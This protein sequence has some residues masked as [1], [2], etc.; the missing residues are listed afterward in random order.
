M[1]IHHIAGPRFKCL[2]HCMRLSYTIPL[3]LLTV[4]DPGFADEWVLYPKLSAGSPILGIGEAIQVEGF[5]G[6]EPAISSD[7][8]EV[9][10]RF[11][12]TLGGQKPGDI[13]RATRKSIDE[14]FGSPVPVEEINTKEFYE[15]APV[16]SP[17]GL[18][19][20]FHTNRFQGWDWLGDIAKAERPSREAAFGPVVN[21]E[22]LNSEIYSDVL[23]GVTSD[24]LRA[25]LTRGH[26]YS[27]RQLYEARRDEPAGPW[28]PPV[29]ISELA[30]PNLE[31]GKGCLSP[32][33]SLLIFSL[34]VPF[35]ESDLYCTIRKNVDAPFCKPQAI[36]LLNTDKSEINPCL[37]DALRALYFV[38]S[39][40][41]KT[42]LYKASILPIR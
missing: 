9:F 34:P 36:S 12:S 30:Q 20:Y 14:P 28:E 42:G 8:L 1:E 40:T 6:T 22:S 32:D 21:V 26:G 23:F 2:L 27:P 37:S 15:V 39:G 35:Q 13:W 29:L 16:L 25:V 41:G 19:L 24:G 33:G 4:S 17:D 38:S 18:T 11:G 5:T 3:L 10:I 31:F 7:G